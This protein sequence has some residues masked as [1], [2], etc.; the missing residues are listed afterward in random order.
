[1]SVWLKRE[2]LVPRLGADD[3]AERTGNVMLEKLGEKHPY[4]LVIVLNY[5][6]LI[7]AMKQIFSLHTRPA[8]LAG[9]QYMII[10]SKIKEV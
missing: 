10:E 2:R 4:L 7:Q 8:W 5:I 6:T 9:K 1:M 3:L